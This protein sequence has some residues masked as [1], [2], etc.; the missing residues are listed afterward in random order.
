MLPDKNELNNE[1]IERI[2]GGKDCQ[3]KNGQKEEAALFKGAVFHYICPTCGM[4]Y[5]AAKQRTDG[6]C[7]NCESKHLE[8]SIPTGDM[9]TTIPSN[10]KNAFKIN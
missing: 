3:E 4:T 9:Q 1:L 10:N 7:P 5:F 6:F 8:V 2:S